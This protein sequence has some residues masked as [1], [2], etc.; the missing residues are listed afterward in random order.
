MSIEDRVTNE[1]NAYDGG[2]V[3]AASAALQRRFQH[4]F[5]CPDSQRLERH[6]ELAIEGCCAGGDILNL[7]CYEGDETPKFMAFGAKRIVG[8]DIS[9]NAIATAQRKYGQLAEFHVMDGHR[10]TFPPR[11]FDAVIGRSILHHLDFP[12]AIL[13]IERVLRP[14]GSAIFVEPLGDNPAAKLIRAFTPRARTSDER[15]L[16]AAQIAWANRKFGASEHC[17]GNLA[18]VPLAMI[19][20]LTSLKAD[21]PLLRFAAR[22]DQ[23]IAATPLRNWMRSVV[24]VWKKSGP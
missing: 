5:H 13:E 1:K 20:S 14:N 10:T 2:D 18:S 21:N 6:M 12:T 8:I 22:I 16:S 23:L 24:L 19:T 15:P 11:S 7:G 4:V 3:A 17:F 9:D